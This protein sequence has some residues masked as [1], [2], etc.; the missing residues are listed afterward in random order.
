M[1]PLF[2]A[3]PGCFR[4]GWPW[5]RRA[6]DAHI[7][8]QAPLDKYKWPTGS[9]FLREPQARS[10]KMEGPMEAWASTHCVHAM[11]G[12][13]QTWLLA[14]SGCA[15]PFAPLSTPAPGSFRPWPICPLRWVAPPTS[16]QGPLCFSNRALQRGCLCNSVPSP[17][18]GTR[19]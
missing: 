4:Q 1:L 10:E 7:L 5:T 18:A 14:T 16:S 13:G 19:L 3:R 11:L 17:G 6:E 12:A 2:P 15:G 9:K 8:L